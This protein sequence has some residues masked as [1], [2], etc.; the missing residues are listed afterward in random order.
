MQCASLRRPVTA[1]L[2]LVFVLFTLG[3]GAE[4]FHSLEEVHLPHHKHAG[5]VYHEPLPCD[6]AESHLHF[7]P[8]RQ[9]LTVAVEVGQDY[10]SVAVELASPA[11]PVC[12]LVPGT[13]L[14]AIRAP[15]SLLS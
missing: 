13:R 2:G 4:I 15:P 7:C 9:Q 12:V 1:L 5:T 6:S 14:R 3:K 11:S 10:T 8:H